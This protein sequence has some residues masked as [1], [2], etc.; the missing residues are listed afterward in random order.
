MES[1]MKHSC[2]S[3]YSIHLMCFVEISSE[4]HM[5]QRDTKPIMSIP[6]C[7]KF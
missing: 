2:F 7:Y 1:L 5:L 3:N 4:C 6:E